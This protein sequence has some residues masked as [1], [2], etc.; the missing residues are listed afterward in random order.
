[1]VEAPFTCLILERVSESLESRKRE[2]L[3]KHFQRDLVVFFIFF[4]MTLE[5]NRTE[6]K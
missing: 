5:R 1:M 2:K 6:F 4:R 3:K